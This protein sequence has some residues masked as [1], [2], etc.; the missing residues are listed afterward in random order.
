[1][2][3]GLAILERDCRSL[4]WWRWRWAEVEARAD[5]AFRLIVAINVAE[6]NRCTPAVAARRINARSRTVIAAPP[7]AKAAQ[8]TA[9]RAAKLARDQRAVAIILRVCEVVV[10]VEQITRL[11]ARAPPAA[12]GRVGD[13]LAGLAIA[14]GT[15]GAA[16]G[17]TA[18]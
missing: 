5:Q 11:Q 9:A 7:L 13:C 2:A 1:M 14:A 6:M 12:R 3:V 10:R 18:L 16:G 8:R 4:R 15:G 17:S